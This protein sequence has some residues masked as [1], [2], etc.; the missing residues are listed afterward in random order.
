VVEKRAS[1]SLL[2]GRWL[3]DQASKPWPGKLRFIS[4]FDFSIKHQHGNAERSAIIIHREPCKANRVWILWVPVIVKKIVGRTLN[5]SRWVEMTPRVKLQL[6]D[7]LDC[8]RH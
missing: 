6:C 1:Y 2:S 7:S 3:D 4:G 5:R 8:M